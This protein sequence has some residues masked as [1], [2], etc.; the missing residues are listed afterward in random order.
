MIYCSLCGH[1]LEASNSPNPC[2]K[3]GSRDKSL[4]LSDSAKGRDSLMIK[5]KCSSTGK[6]LFEST[7]RN[8]L[9]KHGK[10]AK[11]LLKIDHRHPTKTTKT[12]KVHE[13]N[14]DGWKLVHDEYEEYPANR[15][16]TVIK[17][18]KKK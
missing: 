9:S 1:K 18:K 12:H 7:H 13:L 10:E 5:A 16:G 15:K 6:K 3:C 14:E 4:F 11:E 8:K 2:P 17:S